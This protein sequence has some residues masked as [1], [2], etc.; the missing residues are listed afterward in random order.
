MSF[1]G[2]PDSRHFRPIY[3]F[4]LLLSFLASL[5]QAVI[6]IGDAPAGLKHQPGY[7]RQL[8]EI[9]LSTVSVGLW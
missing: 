5:A 8:G 1:F 4:L 2:N 6:Q 7:A 9:N 3:T